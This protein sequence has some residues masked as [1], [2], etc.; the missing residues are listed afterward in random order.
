MRL[1]GLVLALGLVCRHSPP[2][3]S[4][5]EGLPAR[6]DRPAKIISDPSHPFHSAA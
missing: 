6:A 3:R 5:R 2:K 4:K 1:I